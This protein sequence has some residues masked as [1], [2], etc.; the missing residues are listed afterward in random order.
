MKKKHDAFTLTNKGNLQ[1]KDR[2]DCPKYGIYVFLVGGQVIR[3]GE[4]GS[5]FSR[6][7]RGFNSKLVKANKK[8]N[9]AAY[10][11]RVH[12]KNTEVEIRYFSDDNEESLSDPVMRRGIEAELAYRFREK[13]GC[14]PQY[15]TEM[16][17]LNDL[18]RAHKKLIDEIWVDL[19]TPVDLIR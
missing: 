6:I 1:T 2:L 15:M 9:Y 13:N 10:H 11:F 18:N 14:W 4:S 19:T 8:K 17:C 16:H 5:G 3:F 12:L 7:Q